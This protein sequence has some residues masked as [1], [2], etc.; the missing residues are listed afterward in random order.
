[1]IASEALTRNKKWV[2]KALYE[3]G[4]GVVFGEGLMYHL[5]VG[6]RCISG[7][8]LAKFASIST[9]DTG[10]WYATIIETSLA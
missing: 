5:L 9:F 10:C 4:W 3:R 2:L 7:S 8:H 1:M 6:T